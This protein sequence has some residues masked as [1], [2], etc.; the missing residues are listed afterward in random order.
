MQLF[1]LLFDLCCHAVRARTSI[2]VYMYIHMYIH[3]FNV[4]TLYTC[5]LYTRIHYTY[6][7]Y[8]IQC[9]Q[10]V[11]GDSAGKGEIRGITSLLRFNC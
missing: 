8:N 9:L 3:M 5:I 4:Y 10:W 6:T 11:V 1:Y 7:R 2:H